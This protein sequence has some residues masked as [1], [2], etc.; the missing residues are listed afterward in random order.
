MDL[1][2]SDQHRTH[3]YGEAREW[4]SLRRGSGFQAS[5]QLPAFD[6]V[7][8]ETWFTVADANFAL[9]KVTDATTKYYY[10]LSKLD[11]ESLGQLSAFLKQ[12][13][14]EDPYKEIKN[15]MCEA[16]EPPLEEKL[17][18][19]FAL[20]DLGDDRPRKFGKELQR[21]TADATL[22][23][24]LK[25]IFVRLLPQR[26]VKAITGSLGGNFENAITEADKAWMAAATSS[27][28]ASVSAVSSTCSAAAL[29]S[30]NFGPQMRGGKRGGR[31]QW[32]RRPTGVRMT[33]MTLC[34]FH[35]KFDDSALKC[36]LGCSRW[37]GER[38]R[39]SRVFQI[40]GALDGE[41]AQEDK[42]RPREMRRSVAEHGRNSTCQIRI[43]HRP[44]ISEEMSY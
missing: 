36:A 34:E 1:A 9:R 12:P 15:E 31:R 21:L 33:T 16:Y 18:A 41:D 8:P 27:A 35:K 2:L 6:K 38:S 44:A 4:Y 30:A 39:E 24:M 19:L 37:N 43:N 26:I 22:E 3:D 25:R 7:D 29:V 32:D 13:K 28:A 40:K 20:T 42:T 23:D 11:A 10:V 5:V 14:S 17:D